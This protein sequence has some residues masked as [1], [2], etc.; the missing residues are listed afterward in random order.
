MTFT[1]PDF[2][3]DDKAEVGT[4]GAEVLSPTQLHEESSIEGGGLSDALA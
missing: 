1:L 2:G 4:V 3:K